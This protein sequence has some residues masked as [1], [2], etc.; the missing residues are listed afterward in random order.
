MRGNWTSALQ[1]YFDQN[2]QIIRWWLYILPSLCHSPWNCLKLFY[3]VYWLILVYCQCVILLLCKMVYKKDIINV[4]IKQ[5]ISKIKQVCQS[6]VVKATNKN[7][8]GSVTGAL[9]D[10]TLSVS[11]CIMCHHFAFHGKFDKER[12]LGQIIIIYHTKRVM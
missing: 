8:N 10:A 1:L 6:T 2:V 7:F 11:F 12:Y 3:L 4:N 5:V 9:N